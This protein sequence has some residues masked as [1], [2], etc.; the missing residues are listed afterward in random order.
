MRC[1]C[2]KSGLPCGPLCHQARLCANTSSSTADGTGQTTDELP[3]TGGGAEP[4]ADPG[5]ESASARDAEKERCLECDAT[6]ER[7]NG[8]DGETG[9]AC[10]SCG[11]TGAPGQDEDDEE[12]E[13]DEPA[14]DEDDGREGRMPALDDS[15]SDDDNIGSLRRSARIA[16]R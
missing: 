3:E 11:A 15:D 1:A 13:E 4:E 16:L 6:F 5:D 12:E 7:E 14:D 9:Q 8:A 10:P 2:R